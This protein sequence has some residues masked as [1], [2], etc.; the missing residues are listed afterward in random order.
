MEFNTLIDLIFENLKPKLE[1]SEGLAVFAKEHANFDEWLKVELCGIFSQNCQNTCPDTQ[2]A[3][4]RVDDWILELKTASPNIQYTQLENEQT[5]ATNNIQSIINDID[6]LS[7][8]DAVKKAA[9]IIAF[10]LEPDNVFWQQQLNRISARLIIKRV[11]PFVFKGE[12]V[13]GMIYLGTV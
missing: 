3:G 12:A 1:A 6:K 10:P 9:L 7:Q 13:K 11:C 5:P 2:W 8:S 4:L